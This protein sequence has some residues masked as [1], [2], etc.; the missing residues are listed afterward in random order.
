M[1]LARLAGTHSVCQPGPEGDMAARRRPCWN[2]EAEGAEEGEN[3]RACRPSG[4]RARTCCAALAGR[5]A[6]G[7]RARSPRSAGRRSRRSPPGASHDGRVVRR[8]DVRARRTGLP[9]PP[10]ARCSR[11]RHRRRRAAPRGG[12]PDGVLAYHVNQRTREI[13]IRMALGSEP[14]WILRLGARRGSLLV[15]IGL[16]SGLAGALALRSAIAAG[17]YGVGP[18]D[19]AV[20]LGAGTMLAA[21]LVHRVPRAG[22]AGRACQPDRRAVGP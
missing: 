2:G 10:G 8:G 22:P 17:L 13:G 11:R 18:L 14:S 20:M 12:R 9:Y 4:G 16:A 21:S 7:T 6:A 5:F 19:P 15:A 3:A 1:Q